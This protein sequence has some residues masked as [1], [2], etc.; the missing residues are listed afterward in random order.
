LGREIPYFADNLVSAG[1][2]WGIQDSGFSPSNSKELFGERMFGEE[3][4]L[5]I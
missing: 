4:L 2:G 5:Q 1:F 3:I